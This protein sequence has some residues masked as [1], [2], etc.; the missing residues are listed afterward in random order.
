MYNMTPEAND[1]MCPSVVFD[2]TPHRMTT[3]PPNTAAKPLR[4]VRK[5]AVSGCFS[6]SSRVP[7]W[8]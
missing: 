2:G 3:R 4:D 7:L 8:L 6:L 5:M 1:S